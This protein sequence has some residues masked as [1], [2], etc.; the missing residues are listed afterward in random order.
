M[1]LYGFTIERYSRRKTVGPFTRLA[2]AT[3][4]NTVRRRK[5]EFLAR[6]ESKAHPRSLVVLRRSHDRHIS[7]LL[8]N[9]RPVDTAS[10]SIEIQVPTDSLQTLERYAS[11]L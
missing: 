11:A 1:K 6:Q 7:A 4:L 10:V 8:V 9:G 5:A 3:A 2:R